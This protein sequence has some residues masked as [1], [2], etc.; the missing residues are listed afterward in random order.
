MP[1]RAPNLLEIKDLR[2]E[3]AVEGG[4]V[5]VIDG[6]S[7]SLAP[8][9][10]LAI[11]GESGSG[12]SVTAQAV[13]RL[14]PQSMPITGGRILF[15]PDPAAPAID[16]AAVEPDGKAIQAVRGDRIAMVFQEPMSSFSPVH[17]IG[18]QIGDV[19]RLHRGMSG[20]N[21]RARMAELLGKV[22]IPDPARAIDRYPHEFSG[23]MRQRAMIAKALACNPALLI[24]DEP[25]TA[26]DVTIQA[27]VLDLM[28]SL[29]AEYGMAMIFITHD[30]GIVAQMADDVAIMYTGRIVEHGPVRAIF[31]RPQHPY[32]GDLLRAVPRLGGAGGWRALK[33]IQGSVPNLFGMPSGCTFHPRCA[34]FVAGRCDA[35]FPGVTTVGPGHTVRCHLFEAAA[36]NAA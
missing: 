26:L 1:D 16:L 27:Q 7:L 6:V 12:K 21:L 10:V 4:R 17:T 11:V 32:T 13:L 14:L 2:I 33:P 18:A 24:A 34:R 8:G 35:A 23:G 22:G 15:R 19:L 9:R 20:E 28:R 25:T 3:L 36:E 5:P 30:L 29:K 31:R